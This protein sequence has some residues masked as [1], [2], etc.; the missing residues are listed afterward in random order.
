[1][2]INFGLDLVL[3]WLA[4][5]GWFVLFIGGVTH[6]SGSWLVY[7][8]FSAVFLA[9]LVFGYLKIESYGY[10]YLTV[11][12]WLGFWLKLTVHTI[13]NYPFVEAIGAFSGGG[14][15]WDEVLYVATLASLGVMIGRLTYRSLGF[16]TRPKKDPTVPFWYADRRKILWTGLIVAAVV[17]FWINAQYG[18]H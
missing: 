4:L 9:M 1:M 13:I 3:K 18:I 8:M 12:L 17:H 11:L 2:K 5:C 6:Y 10:F 16:E 14:R 15:E 7:T